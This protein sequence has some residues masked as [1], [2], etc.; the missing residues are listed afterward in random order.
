MFDSLTPPHRKSSHVLSLRIKGGREEERN[1]NVRIE[2]KERKVL[3]AVQIRSKPR[4]WQSWSGNDT[5][6]GFNSTTPKPH[7]P[8]L[9][10]CMLFSQSFASSLLSLLFLLS[11]L[12]YTQRFNVYVKVLQ[13]LLS[14]S[15]VSWGHLHPIAGVN[16]TPLSNPATVTQVTATPYKTNRSILSN[17]VSRFNKGQMMSNIY[18]IDPNLLDHQHALYGGPCTVGG[19]STWLCG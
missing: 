6:S 13:C 7:W 9:C 18:Y 1:V 5:G 14:N 3:C 11:S 15:D 19:P 8:Q 12:G 4:G 2:T 17:T 10:V 16:P